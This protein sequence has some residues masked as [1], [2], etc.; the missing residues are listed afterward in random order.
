MRE[1]RDCRSGDVAAPAVLDRH[2][3]AHADAE[4]ARLNGPGQAAEF[5][6]LQ[7]DYVHRQVGLGA[8]QNIQVVDILIQHERLID[9]PARANPSWSGAAPEPATSRA[10]WRLYNI[11]NH[12]PVEVTHVVRLIEEALGRRA[13]RELLPMQ[14]GDVVETYADV[15]DLEAA[16]GF[17]PHTP[18]EEGIGR[19]I[20]WF[21]EFRTLRGER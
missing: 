1:M 8:E 2:R 10:P 11:G 14:P 7:I 17:T 6:D 12:R 21:K 9:L 19:F 3:D 4:I 16:V 5:A 13:T 15:A 18:I 20:A